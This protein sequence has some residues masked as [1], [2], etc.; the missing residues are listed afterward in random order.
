MTLAQK[1]IG[2]FRKAAVALRLADN[3]RSAQVQRCSEFAVHFD[4]KASQS[5]V[6]FPCPW[7]AE[8]FSKQK[9]R[10]AIHVM[11]ADSDSP[12]LCRHWK[13]RSSCPG[14]DELL[15]R[16]NADVNLQI[17]LRSFVLRGV[18]LQLDTDTFTSLKRS[19]GTK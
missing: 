19:D 17:S 6:Q 14:N 1:V 13:L 4:W 2:R 7:W 11:G 9:L 10:S 16:A 18:H 3:T 15:W 8:H 5:V 12:T